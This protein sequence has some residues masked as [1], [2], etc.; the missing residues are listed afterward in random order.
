[1]HEPHEP[2]DKT[3]L[4]VQ[5]AAGLGLPHE[6]IGA[7]IGVCDKTVRKYYQTEL[8]LGKATASA[9]IAK[10]LY[11]KAV[12]GDTTAMIWWTKAQMN[13]GET[14]RQELTGKDGEELKGL[15]VNFV[16]PNGNN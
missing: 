2:T 5:Q 7:L 14:I 15:T 10:T 8:A 11:N 12:A 13:W 9:S 16:K 4:Q 1:M 6:Q 3:R